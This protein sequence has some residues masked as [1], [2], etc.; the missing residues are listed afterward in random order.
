MTVRNVRNNNPGNIRLSSTEWVGAVPGSDSSFVTFATPEAGVRAMTKNLYSY[1]SRYGLG[2]VNEMISRWAPPN[3]NNTTAYV[4]RVAASMGVD[5]NQTINLRDNPQ[6]TERMV[7]VMIREEGGAEAANYFSPHIAQGVVDAN[8]S[9]VTYPTS[10]SPAQVDP[11][12][13]GTEGSTGARNYNSAADITAIARPEDLASLESSV[14]WL[15]NALDDYENYTY[16]LELFLVDQRSAADFLSPTGTSLDSIVDDAWPGSGTQKIIIAKTGITTE[17][18]IQDLEIQSLGATHQNFGIVG[19]ALKLSF[20]I[21]QVG[22]SK[23][24][25]I[26]KSAT[27][28]AGYSNIGSAKFFL[29]INFMGYDENGNS[30]R[31]PR[32]TKVIPFI[33]SNTAEVQTSSTI[34]GT[35]TS[36]EGSVVRYGAMDYGADTISTSF[37]YEIGDNVE[38][39][40]NNLLTKYNE[41]LVQTNFGGDTKFINTY[42]VKAINDDIKNEF[43]V[44]NKVMLDGFPNFGSANHNTYRSAAPGQMATAMPIGTLNPG[45]SLM[46]SILDVFMNSEVVKRN[47]T[48]DQ[49]S[50]TDVLSIYVDYVPKVDGYN[51]MTNTEG[52]DITYYIG[53]KRE[54][55]EQSAASTM[56]HAKNN[57][58]IVDEIVNEGKLKKIYRY[59]Y[60]GRNDQVLNFEISLK[61]QL[62]KT[63][64]S[65]SGEQMWTKLLDDYGIVLKSE[66]G[67]DRAVAKLQEMSSAANTTR[68]SLE[69]ARASLQ[70]MTSD[71]TTWMTSQKDR[72]I[73][74]LTASG[75]PAEEVARAQSMSLDQLLAHNSTIGAT[76]GGANGD[77]LRG[78]TTDYL[79]RVLSNTPI[80]RLR[81]EFET[82]TSQL[83]DIRNTVNNLRDS[84]K[85][86]DDELTR[87]IQT[88][89]GQAINALGGA[90]LVQNLST[91]GIQTSTSNAG[92]NLGTY[93]LAENMTSDSINSIA[94]GELLSVLNAVSTNPTIFVELTKGILAHNRQL[95]SIATNDPEYVE[96]AKEKYYEAHSGDI[97]MMEATME[98]RGDPFWIDNHISPAKYQSEF[99]KNTNSNYPNDRSEH[100]GFNYVMIV[101]NAVDG[102]D[103]NDNPKIARLLTY[104]YNVKGITSRFDG[105]KFTQTLD[106]VRLH[107]A[108]GYKTTQGSEVLGR[109]MVP[110]ENDNSTTRN[111]AR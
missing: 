81:S 80:Q 40:I 54:L 23:L 9:T 89:F 76:S 92:A 51:V 5:P 55:V 14:S 110:V 36:I 15:P 98:I 32:S 109:S 73:E 38:D 47:L 72:I 18:N 85:S 107:I 62:I 34:A 27:L 90:G 21:V 44:N 58:T 78:G 45:T 56:V 105:G 106:M 2:T 7:S 35:T 94:P 26:L 88:I 57:K 102:E 97:S 91:A 96:L 103:E 50:F 84:I 95:K 19:A 37:E 108:D 48:E 101:S 75:A 69:E 29:K 52:A 28:L 100:N 22:R 42:S 65:A 67:N 39:T 59:L 68:S 104:I 61:Q 13:A 17:F 24:A 71:N 20:S 82:R 8:S 41:Y 66:L 3:E 4:N 79:A 83:G 63:Y 1:Q 77:G 6:L 10:T 12:V 74:S 25:E 53:K 93:V 86:A 49:V 43:F 87:G 30:F 11:A 70:S 16:N 64:V 111:L 46:E 31:I 60:T 99:T 33:I